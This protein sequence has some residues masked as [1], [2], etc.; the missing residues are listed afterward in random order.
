MRTEWHEIRSRLRGIKS[1]AL[2]GLVLL[3]L[4]GVPPLSIQSSIV[5]ANNDCEET[6]R[7]E[8]QNDVERILGVHA[9]S[10]HSSGTGRSVYQ[11]KTPRLNRFGRLNDQQHFSARVL[12]RSLQPN[13]PPALFHFFG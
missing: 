7:S 8:E 13:P 9:Q 1:A 11:P 3:I 6:D 2:L 10:V 12:S 5:S 4:F